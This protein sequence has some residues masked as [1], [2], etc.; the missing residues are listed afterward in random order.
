MK[1]AIIGMG[2]VGRAVASGVKNWMSPDTFS[3]CTYDKFHSDRTHN[4]KDFL[5]TGICFVCVS[6]PTTAT[7]QDLD[8]VVETMKMLEASI[9]NGVVVI[10][11]T[12]EPGTMDSLARRYPGLRLVHN[13]EFL[14]EKTANKDFEL[15]QSVLLSGKP[16]D[17]IVASNFYQLSPFVATV[18]YSDQYKTTEFAKYIHNCV[19]AVKLSFLNEMYDLIDSPVVYEGAT[20]MAA[21]FGNLGTHFKV[22]GTDGKRGWAG[23][24]FPKDMLAL[25][26]YAQQEAKV[27]PTIRGAIET[28]KKHRPKEMKR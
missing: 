24:C 11:S 13:P 28:N 20:Q 19:L 23:M 7:G 14:S 22:P 10:K 27:V 18:R 5:Q 8:A 2:V 3:L 16:E 9:Y 25:Q 4:W 26:A 6:T 21:L 17:A 12:V 15:Q 1:I